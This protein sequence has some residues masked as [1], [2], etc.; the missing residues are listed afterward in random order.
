MEGTEPSDSGTE[1]SPQHFLVQY[2]D[3]LYVTAV[4]EEADPADPRFQ[5]MWRTA[6][7][8]GKAIPLAG[9][10][11]KSATFGNIEEVSFGNINEANFGNI[12][13]DDDDS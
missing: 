2:Q 5:D 3:R 11:V 12:K 10:S 7:E 8:V 6:T 13:S 1:T 4:L 9:V